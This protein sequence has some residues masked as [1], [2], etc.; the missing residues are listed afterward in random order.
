MTNETI[1]FN[2]RCELMKQGKINGTGRMIKV[3][4]DNG[5]IEMEEPQQIHTF[6]VWKS[7]GFSVKKGEHAICKLDIWKYTA[8]QP[9]KLTG[10]A[11]EDA[12]VEHLFRKVAAFFSPD[13]VEVITAKA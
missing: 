9:E 1:V 2:A 13:Q 6:S 10:N 3:V 12:P 5:E 11:V 7:M 8:K 4:T